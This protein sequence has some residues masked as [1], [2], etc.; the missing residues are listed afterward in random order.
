MAEERCRRLYGLAISA[1]RPLGLLRDVLCE[2]KAGHMINEEQASLDS[3]M[4]SHKPHHVD[5][6]GVLKRIVARLHAHAPS[7]ARLPEILSQLAEESS[8]APP[9]PPARIT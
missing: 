5:A 2:L 4:C 7:L 6:K 8:E 3:D 1:T 9:V